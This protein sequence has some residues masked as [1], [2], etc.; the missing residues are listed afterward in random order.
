M[1]R[2]LPGS[3]VLGRAL[4]QAA[5]SRRRHR[6][7]RILENRA[8]DSCCSGTPNYASVPERKERAR[9]GP[10]VGG[11]SFALAG[12]WSAENLTSGLGVGRRTPLV[13]LRRRHFKIRVGLMLARL[14]CIAAQGVALL[15]CDLMH[16]IRFGD[17]HVLVGF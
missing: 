9:R 13:R 10:G 1:P 15:Y 2:F 14:P 5:G 3:P 7:M 11:Y 12:V 4:D 6:R 8:T 17:R 16:A